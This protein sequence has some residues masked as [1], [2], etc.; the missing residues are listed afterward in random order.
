MSKLKLTK[1]V[2]LTAK[3]KRDILAEAK[4]RGFTNKTYFTSATGMPEAFVK[5]KLVVK[6]NYEDEEEAQFNGDVVSSAGWG[7]IYCA[8]TNKWGEIWEK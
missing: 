7:V 2:K 3:Y 5:G 6:E 4:S 1:S 8:K